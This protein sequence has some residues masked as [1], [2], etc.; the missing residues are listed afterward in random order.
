MLIRIAA[1]AAAAMLLVG[2]LNIEEALREQERK[3]TAQEELIDVEIDECGAAEATGTIRNRNAEATRVS[4][5]IWW[6]L[7][8]REP[9]RT[10]V[11]HATPI[12]AGEVQEWTADVTGGPPLDANAARQVEC[13][14][15]S[16][17]AFPF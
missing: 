13:R 11:A 16:V 6:I 9:V 12:G 10:G 8:G 17:V 7:G 1:I 3:A 4:I 2:C 5:V 14:V 15:E